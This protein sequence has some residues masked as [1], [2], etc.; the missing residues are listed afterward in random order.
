MSQSLNPVYV[1][2]T[3]V[4]TTAPA[5]WES[6]EAIALHLAQGYV[7]LWQYH[8]IF[9]GVIE[10]GGVRWLNDD[11]PVQSDDHLVRLRA[12]NERQEYHFWRNGKQ[13]KGRL[14]TDAEGNSID[15]IDTRMKL[16]SI[17]GKPL[18]KATPDLVSDELAVITR[19]YIGYDE[20]TKQA[21]YMDSRFLNLEP[22]NPDQA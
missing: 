16:R 11:Q 15:T 1:V 19:N 14:R 7:I 6:I 20:T 5:E 21:S 8:A 10:S 22:F 3:I 17:V 18:R 13:I 12:F 2:Q 4:S 9:T